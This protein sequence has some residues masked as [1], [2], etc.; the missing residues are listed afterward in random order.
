MNIFAQN[1]PILPIMGGFSSNFVPVMGAFF[2]IRHRLH[3][4]I[5]SNFPSKQYPEYRMWKELYSMLQMKKTRI[6]SH[7][8]QSNG[9]MERFN[10]RLAGMPRNKLEMGCWGHVFMGSQSLRTVGKPGEPPEQRIK[11]LPALPGF[12]TYSCHFVYL[13]RTTAPFHSTKFLQPQRNDS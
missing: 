12:C 6:T 4:H 1:D 8:P 13:G 9:F 2:M 10:R 3:S 11:Q 5:R 7:R